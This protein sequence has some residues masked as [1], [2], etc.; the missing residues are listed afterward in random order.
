VNHE[1]YMRQAIQ[2]A[3]QAMD[4]GEVPVGCVIVDGEGA[5]IGKGFNRREQ[6]RSALAH[7]EIEAI[8]EACAALK[9]WRLTGCSLY[10]TLE[11][12]PM[13]AGAIINARLSKVFY[14][15]KEPVSGACGSIIN[16][17]MEPFGHSPQLVGGILEEEC[18]ALMSEFFKKL[19]DK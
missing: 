8:S 1:D 11:P 4:Q 6:N 19:R 18:A 5:V 3:R 14:G 16:L 10:V 2:L 12:C 7:A 17:F 13:C 9:D 15:A